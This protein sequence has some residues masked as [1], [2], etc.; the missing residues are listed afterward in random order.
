MRVYWFVAT[1]LLAVSLFLPV[2]PVF[3][4]YMYLDSNGDGVNDLGDRL[5]ANG[6]PTTVDVYLVTGH[7]RDGS[8]AACNSDSLTTLW[9]APH[10]D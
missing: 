6:L 3:A 10:F 8:P 5:N 4:Q 2:D 1:L 7:N 9:N